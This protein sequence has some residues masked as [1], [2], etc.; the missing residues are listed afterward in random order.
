VCDVAVSPP[1]SCSTVGTTAQAGLKASEHRSGLADSSWYTSARACNNSV[2]V[3]MHACRHVTKAKVK[4]QK[5]SQKAMYRTCEHITLDHE[6]TPACSLHGLSTNQGVAKTKHSFTAQ[7]STVKTVLV[8]AVGSQ[9]SPC[10]TRH[11]PSQQ[12]LA[13]CHPAVVLLVTSVSPVPRQHCHYCY[14]CCC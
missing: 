6:R 3:N 10:E 8:P 7:T 13:G 4:I 5:H 12:I 1:N 2:C 9:H 14:Y 11:F